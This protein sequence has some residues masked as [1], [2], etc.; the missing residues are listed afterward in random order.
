MEDGKLTL[1]DLEGENLDQED[2][3]LINEEMQKAVEET[4]ADIDNLTPEEEE[5]LDKEFEQI[6]NEPDPTKRL[7]LIKKFHPNMK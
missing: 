3:D 5:Q 2:I 7:E 4:I 1:K 6:M